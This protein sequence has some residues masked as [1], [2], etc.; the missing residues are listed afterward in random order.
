MEMVWGHRVLITAQA[1]SMLSRLWALLILKDAEDAGGAQ[2]CRN[3]PDWF[4][5]PANGSPCP[6][7]IISFTFQAKR[8]F[9]LKRRREEKDYFV[10]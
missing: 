7:S 2:G 8:L 6:L 3:F 5:I 4:G 10:F 1:C 9:L